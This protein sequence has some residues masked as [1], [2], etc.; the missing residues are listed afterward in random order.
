V[1][2]QAQ[3]KLQMVQMLLL[4]IWPITYSKEELKIAR[5]MIRNSRIYKRRLKTWQGKSKLK[6]RKLM[7]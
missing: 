7:N 2:I 6:E 1:K 4:L 3:V 5:R